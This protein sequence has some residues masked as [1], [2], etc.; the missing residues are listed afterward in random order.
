MYRQKN[1]TNGLF[2]AETFWF[3][4]LSPRDA[5][6]ANSLMHVQMYA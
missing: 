6:P 3:F 5:T 1:A 4:H 2:L